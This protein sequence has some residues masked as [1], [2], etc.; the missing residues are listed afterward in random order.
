MIVAGLKMITV[1][2]TH[3]IHAGCT[4][5]KL[6]P[7]ARTTITAKTPRITTTTV[8]NDII[9]LWLTLLQNNTIERHN[10]GTV[11]R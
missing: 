1:I 6:G 3:A 7:E 10:I 11:A 5:L 9:M 2:K 8:R 4:H